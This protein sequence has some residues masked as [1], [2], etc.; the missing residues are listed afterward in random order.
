M[1]C[2]NV[3][4]FKQVLNLHTCT[5]YI[6][7]Y[8]Y[9]NARVNNVVLCS[10]FPLLFAEQAPGRP[11]VS[12]SKQTGNDW[13]MRASSHGRRHQQRPPPP[14]YR[15]SNLIFVAYDRQIKANSSGASEI[16]GRAAPRDIRQTV[17]RRSRHIVVQSQPGA[18]DR[19]RE[20]TE[21]SRSKLRDKSASTSR[22]SK[23]ADLCIM[24][25]RKRADGLAFRTQDASS[26]PR[27]IIAETNKRPASN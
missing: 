20:R 13:P 19:E 1:F 7:R 23:R 24:R 17:F 15:W 26:L 9:G 8:R 27:A 21:P 6:M 10:K 22:W 14:P 25:A 2:V 3:A 11:A 12:L 4:K 18:R 16:K 5:Q